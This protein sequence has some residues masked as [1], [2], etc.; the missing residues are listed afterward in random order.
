MY[1]Q[2]TGMREQE[3]RLRSELRQI[4]TSS[5]HQTGQKLSE[6]LHG[7]VRT[8]G[9][10]C[11]DP[12]MHTIFLA[13]SLLVLT[14]VSLVVMLVPDLLGVLGCPVLITSGLMVSLGGAG[15]S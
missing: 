15:L 1:P 10:P 13:L 9:T 12:I 7:L 3:A 2:W 5:G 6:R 11:P 14:A 8:P 4:L